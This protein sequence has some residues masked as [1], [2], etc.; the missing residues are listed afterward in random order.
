MWSP[1]LVPAVAPSGGLEK[2]ALRLQRYV[3]SGAQTIDNFKVKN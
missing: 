2:S 1:A 3:I